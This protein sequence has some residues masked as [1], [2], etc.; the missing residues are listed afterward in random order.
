M[1]NLIFVLMYLMTQFLYAAGTTT[2]A[3]TG[4]ATEPKKQII[5][6]KIEAG[7]IVVPPVPLTLPQSKDVTKKK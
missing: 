2:G 3:K 5:H 6:K 7:K 4:S 1:R